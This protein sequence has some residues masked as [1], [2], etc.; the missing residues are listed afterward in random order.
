MLPDC[1]F[2]EVLR[3][4]GS[5]S[6][7]G[8][9]HCTCSCYGTPKARHCLDTT[10][11]SELV[12]LLNLGSNSDTCGRVGGLFLETVPPLWP[13]C[14]LAPACPCIWE[15]GHLC[16][17][18]QSLNILSVLWHL[19]DWVLRREPDDVLVLHLNKEERKGKKQIFKEII[20]S[21]AENT[22]T[23]H[24]IRSFGKWGHCTQNPERLIP[25][26]AQS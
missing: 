14:S 1:G 8:W 11:A 22:S 17:A 21:F 19:Q 20:L 5:G 24:L 13:L 15:P 18:P 23:S 9:L 16:S 12:L 3:W 2:G 4:E 25:K 7:A 10:A 6:G 26:W